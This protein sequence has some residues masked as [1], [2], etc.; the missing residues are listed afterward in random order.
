MTEPRT[1]TKLSVAMHLMNAKRELRLARREAHE[2]LDH[3]GGPETCTSVACVALS[4]LITATPN[5]D[6]LF[7][8][9]ALREAQGA[10]ERERQNKTDT[11]S[12]R[13]PAVSV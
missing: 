8:D 7:T 1:S 9:L 12:V 10:R 11:A 3:E 13:R 2:G 5:A 4:A 6:T